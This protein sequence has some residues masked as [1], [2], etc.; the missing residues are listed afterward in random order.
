MK[1]FLPLILVAAVVLIATGL[2]LRQ[3]DPAL[4]YTENPEAWKVFEAGESMLQSYRYTEADSLLRRALALDPDLAMA[5]VALA[6]LAYRRGMP[7][8]SSRHYAIADSLAPLVTAPDARLVLMARLSMSESSRFHAQRDSL[9]NAAEAVAPDHIIV[10]LN[11]AMQATDD[12][13]L[14]RAEKLYE[15]ILEINPNYAGA[16][17]FLG[18]LYLGQGKYEA[19]E[20]AMRRYAFVAPDLAN[21]HDSLGDV[22]MTVGRFEEAEVEFRTALAKDPLFF[23]SQINIAWIYLMRGQVDK[24]LELIDQVRE[25]MAGTVFAERTLVDL[26]DR[27]FAQRMTGDLVRYADEYLAEYPDGKRRALVRLRKLLGT[28][29]TAAAMAE[30]D[31]AMT[32][33]RDSK[34]WGTD[35][36]ATTRVETNEMRYRAIAA[37]NL[38][39]HQEAAELFR[40]VLA[41]LKDA[42]PHYK[43]FDR[44]HLAYN[45]IPLQ[46]YDE[47]RVQV[48]EALRVNPRISEGVLVAASIEAAAGEVT[49][50][51]RLLDTVDRVLE[52]ADA[53][54]PVLLEAQR[55][56][57]QLPDPDRI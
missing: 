36:R 31:S 14:E 26:I 45:L 1:R 20:T 19:A 2:F 13:D 10:L 8:E 3:R 54:Y 15:H 34:W 24:G 48:A 11:Q 43:L 44:I 5:H 57:E 17:N 32:E 23:Y 18:Y 47:A 30:L 55:L 22:L 56:R 35:A 9:L 12:E 21:P 40:G 49:E 50:A 4:A 42:P 37:E 52:R 46:A 7:E 28:D 16:Y 51:R 38:G 39:A 33:Y 41:R 53:D 25:E 6:E 29:Q 27:L